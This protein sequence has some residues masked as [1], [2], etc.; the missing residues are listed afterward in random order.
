MKQNMKSPAEE[1]NKLKDIFKKTI[2]RVKDSLGDKPFNIKA[3]LNAAVFD[4]TM[5]AFAL[6]E[7]DPKDIRRRFE[8]LVQNEA[9]NA[10]V[11]SATTDQESVKH[12]IDLANKTLFR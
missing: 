7:K 5:V 11:T 1:L 12:R 2:H 4:S 10:Y 9:Y 3:G 6:N 8:N